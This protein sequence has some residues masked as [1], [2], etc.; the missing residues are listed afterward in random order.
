MYPVSY[1]VYTCSSPTWTEHPLSNTAV[2]SLSS[3]I[4]CTNKY[5]TFPFWKLFPTPL[6]VSKH[7]LTLL[8][9]NVL[10]RRRKFAS[11]PFRTELLKGCPNFQAVYGYPSVHGAVF[12]CREPYSA[13]RCYFISHGPVRCGFSDI[14][15]PTVRCGAVFKKAKILRCGAV[16]FSDVVS[17]TVRFGAT[18]C[19]TVRFGAVFGYRQAYGAVR[20]GFQEGKNPTVR[21]V[22]VRLTAPN[23]TKPIGK[24]AP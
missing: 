22:S 21:C 14:V 7:S 6:S 24:T 18:L 19:P 12:R 9:V 11:P 15:K 4:L 20:C 2:S 13:V 17:P 5:P 16:R 23:R 1:L 10:P 8:L 3:I